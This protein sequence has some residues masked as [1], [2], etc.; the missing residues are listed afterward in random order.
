MTESEWN[1]VVL[2]YGLHESE[3]GTATHGG[4]AD[5]RGRHGGRDGRG[6]RLIGRRNCAW[7]F[8]LLI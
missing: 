3:G 8:N 1:L 6:G 2:L 4:V 7:S 5:A